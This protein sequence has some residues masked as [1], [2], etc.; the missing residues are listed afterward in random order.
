MSEDATNFEFVAE[1]GN[2]LLRH[3]TLNNISLSWMVNFSFIIIY[4]YLI[5]FQNLNT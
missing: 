1:K 5:P 3:F 4:F 2:V